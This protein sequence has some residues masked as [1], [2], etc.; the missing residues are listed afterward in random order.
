VSESEIVHH[1]SED[2]A[3][4]RFIPHVPRTNPS[5]RPAVWAIDSDHASLYWFPR[6]CPRVTAWPRVPGHLAA[7]QTAWHT[8]AHR[9]QAIE[10]EWLDRMLSVTLYR[11]DLSAASFRPW[12]EAEGQWIAHDVLEPLAV[13]PAGDL[14]VLHAR[15]GIELRVTPTLWPLWDLAK[16][17]PWSFSLIRTPNA[18]PRLDNR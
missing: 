17:G 12:P 18:R 8:E 13:V 5:Q 6:D 1:F 15:A 16:G 4:Q 9:V 14:L 11:Y 3:I 7:F 2:P 10:S